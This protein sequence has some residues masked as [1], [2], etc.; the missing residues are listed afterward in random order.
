MSDDSIPTWLGD[1]RIDGALV[2]VTAEGN[3]VAMVEGKAA[4][5]LCPCCSRLMQ[6]ASAARRVC[7]AVYPLEPDAL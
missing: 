6:S 1:R 2:V 5:T 4:L 3:W 7:D